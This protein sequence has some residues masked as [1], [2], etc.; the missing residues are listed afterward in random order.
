MN[1]SDTIYQPNTDTI[2]AMTEAEMI[3]AD[4]SVKGYTDMNELFAELDK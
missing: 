1:D 4:T 2:E 3:V